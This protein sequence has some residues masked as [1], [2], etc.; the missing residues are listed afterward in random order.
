MDML[1]LFAGLYAAY[2]W[3]DWYLRALQYEMAG[4]R[5]LLARRL[6]LFVPPLCGTLIL[7]IL[8]RFSASDVRSDTYY[9][10]VYLGLGVIWLAL[11]KWLFPFLGISLEGDVLERGNLAALA[12]LSGALV[13]ASLCYSGGNIGEGP[14]AE[15]VIF[16]AG[17]ATLAWLLGWYVLTLISEVDYAVTVERD[18]ASGIRLGGYLVASGLILGRAAAGNW[19]SYS[20]T[21]SD[22]LVYGISAAGLLLLLALI[23]ER[24]SRLSVETPRR[25]WL[26]YGIV[27]LLVYNGLAAAYLMT[28]SF[29]A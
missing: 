6:I 16:S 7:S 28:G 24:F 3:G 23:V 19:V 13:G 29:P 10:L 21:V 12:A 11:V 4:L 9:M 22:M 1:I 17:L 8:M 25:S 27:P 15:V 20:A 2:V 18:L 26:T 5:P 14:G